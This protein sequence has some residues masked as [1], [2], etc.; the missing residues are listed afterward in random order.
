MSERR[1]PFWGRLSKRTRFASYLADNRESAYP[2]WL[3]YKFEAGLQLREKWHALNSPQKPLHPVR[4]KAYASLQAPLWQCLFEHFDPE[5]T[6]ASFEA[7]HP[8]LDIRMLR[9]L[10]A[11]PPLPWCRAKYL[12]RKAM[13]GRLPSQ[14]LR[15]GKTT[16]NSRSLETFLAKFCRSPFHPAAEVREYID[17]NRLPNSS[18]LVDVEG[19]LRVRSLNHWLKNWQRSS[20]NP[21]ERVLCDRFAR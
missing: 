10:L 14:V 8:F 20:D 3:T 17:P 13:R 6:K 18:A 11:V 2:S 19:N 7:R 1:P 12:F 4:P 16:P 21:Q 15:R 9:F 5:V